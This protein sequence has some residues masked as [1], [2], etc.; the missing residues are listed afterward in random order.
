[1]HSC[2][3]QSRHVR[4]LGLTDDILVDKI[5]AN[6]L[7]VILY[8]NA[9]NSPM[10][11]TVF[12]DLFVPVTDDRNWSPDV[13]VSLSFNLWLF[14]LPRFLYCGYLYKKIGFTSTCCMSCTSALKLTTGLL[15][16]Q[17]WSCLSNL[18]SWQVSPNY[19]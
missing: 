12:T 18:G 5:F 10:A 9:N 7:P 19:R 13:T 17:V 16:S 14:G 15:Y 2:V 8:N 4:S 11:D 1:M 3:Q 6:F